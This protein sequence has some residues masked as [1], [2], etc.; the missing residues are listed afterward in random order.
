[1]TAS[2][3]PILFIEVVLIVLYF[4]INS[5]VTERVTSAYLDKSKE[6][7]DMVVAREVMLIDEALGEITSYAVMLQNEQQQFF[8]NMDAYELYN[9]SSNLFGYHANGAFY[10]LEN[11]GGSSLYYS[12]DTII[13]A[14]ELRKAYMTEHLD[15]SLKSMVEQNSLIS[16]VYLNTYDNMNRLYPF[17]DNVAERFGSTIHMQDYNF[18]YLADAKHNPERDPVWTSVY[19]DPAG[20]GWIMSCIVPIYRDDFLE[21]VAGIDI[22]VGKMVDSALNM[23]VPNESK[24]FIVDSNGVILAMGDEIEELLGLKELKDHFYDEAISTTVYKPD[25]FNILKHP[26]AE[27]KDKLGSVFAEKCQGCSVTIK[28]HDYFI[29]HKLISSTGWH[30]FVV[31]D[32]GKLVKPIE[33]LKYFSYTLGK[34]VVVAIFIMSL[35]FYI[36]FR[37]RSEKLA[38]MISAPIVSL[39]ENTKYIGSE[40]MA[41]DYEDS[42]IEELQ[43]L[44]INFDEMTNELEQ[45]TR[46]LIHAEVEKLEKEKEAERLLLMSITDP[47]TKLYNR[48]KVDEILDYEI[49]QA[50]RYGKDFSVLI[51]DIDHFKDVNDNFGHQTGDEVLKIIAEL[52][53][54][55][56]R[57]S[58]TVARWGGEEFLII[59]TNTPLE[60]AAT[61]AEKLRTKIESYD[62]PVGRTVTASFGVA[63]YVNGEQKEHFI[64]RADDALYAAKNKSRNVVVAR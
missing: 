30:L 53:N 42:Q 48:I 2:L 5:Y 1:M 39:S 52:L 19:L 64:K 18:Y 34:I 63:Q 11:N 55:N 46:D 62:F 43:Q 17:I 44:N 12:S 6:T 49:E 27:I 24:A 38:N 59:F 45:R 61:I 23:Q 16:Q 33:K 47:L 57:S 7:I 54:D 29:T 4:F 13:G 56:T 10:K 50:G 31:T 32:M 40:F 22:T 3:L 58:D 41:F 51:S 35:M 37:K 8:R 20:L 28:G 26:D 21:G 25:E 9:E 15:T 36:Y 14:E 60:D